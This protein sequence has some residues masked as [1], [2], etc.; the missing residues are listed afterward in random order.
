MALMEQMLESSTVEAATGYG[1]DVADE[2][3][4][5][6]GAQLCAARALLGLSAG[7]LSG[8]TKLSRGTIQRA[9]AEREITPANRVRIVETLEGMGVLFVPSNGEGPGVRLRKKKR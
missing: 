6:T 9:E 4:R 5:I 7:Q 1:G 3:A 8:I 2:K